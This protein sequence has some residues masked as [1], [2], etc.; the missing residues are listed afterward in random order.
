[1]C[2]LLFSLELYT[3]YSFG[4]EL[5]LMYLRYIHMAKNH[6]ATNKII[7]KTATM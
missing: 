4:S 6:N 7:F 5:S 2:V 3:P 1:M